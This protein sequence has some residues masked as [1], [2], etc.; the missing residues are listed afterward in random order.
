MKKENIYSYSAHNVI[1]HLIESYDWDFARIK[2]R[3][4]SGEQTCWIKI[5]L[6]GDCIKQYEFIGNNNEAYTD[7]YYKFL[8]ILKEKVSRIN[9]FLK[10]V[11]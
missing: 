4:G 7:A 6:N 10:D 9:D 5:Y 2:V 8:N 1:N 3:S 11:K